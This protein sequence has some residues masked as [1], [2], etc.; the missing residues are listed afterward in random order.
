MLQQTD[1]W[2]DIMKSIYNKKNTNILTKNN[3]LPKSGSKMNLKLFPLKG[4]KS[5]QL[6][7]PV[8]KV[9]NGQNEGNEMS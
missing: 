6:F 8:V 1:A 3:P 2:S 4:K 7:R 5:G 9:D